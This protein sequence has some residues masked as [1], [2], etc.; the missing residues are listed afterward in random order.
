MSIYKN[1]INSII[2][3]IEDYKQAIEGDHKRYISS[4]RNIFAG[5]LLLFKH[6]LSELSPEGSDEILIKQRVKPVFN[7][8]SKDIKWVGDGA[9]TVDVDGIKN[10]FKNLKIKVDWKTLDKIN[11]YRNNREHYHANESPD[12]VKAM[13]SNCFV[14]IRDFFVK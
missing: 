9:K 1:A 12:S 8:L 11:S 5:I 2:I 13:L 6:K 14:V 7:H 10:R 3:G 4:T